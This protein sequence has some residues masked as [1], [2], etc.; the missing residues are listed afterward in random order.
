METAITSEFL[1]E[2]LSKPSDLRQDVYREKS[3]LFL[4]VADSVKTGIAAADIA[5]KT[6]PGAV[7]TDALSVFNP[8]ASTAAGGKCA[9]FLYPEDSLVMKEIYQFVSLLASDSSLQSAVVITKSPFILADALAEAAFVVS[10]RDGALVARTIHGGLFGSGPDSISDL[11]GANKDVAAFSLSYN[12]LDALLR[13]DW[14]GRKSE[15][16][17]LLDQIGSSFHRAE[18]RAISKGA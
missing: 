14:T 13:K 11:L 3:I 2:Q 12:Y 6:L 10:T 15:L 5:C 18:L 7:R 16:L 8:E 9:V 17:G 4:A 1:I